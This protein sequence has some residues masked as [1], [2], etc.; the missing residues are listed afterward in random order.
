M[1]KHIV[2]ALVA[3]GG[4]AAAPSARAAPSVTA[5]F[6][7]GWQHLDINHPA[8]SVG[9]AVS[10]STGGGL[11]GGDVLLDLGGFGFGASVDKSVSGD[12]TPWTGSVLAG[13]M[14]DVLAVRLE[15]LGELGRRGTDF[16]NIFDSNGNTIVGARPGVSFRLAQL[17]L[18]I[19]ASGLIRWP[20][21]GGDFGS[22]DWGVVGKVGL[23]F[24]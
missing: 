16:G 20:T 5:E 2:M 21:S 14:F 6:Y 4:L 12:V 24:P 22:P 11:I 9:N 23:E 10:G 7:G 19:G 18:R 8:T 15:L 13:F 1:K 3:A 17:P